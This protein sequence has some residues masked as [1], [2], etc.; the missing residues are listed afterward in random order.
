MAK[1]LH[2][3]SSVRNAGSVSRQLTAEFLSK[4]QAVRSADVIVER[5]LA[6]NPVPHLSE[7]MMGAFFT[8]AEQRSLE[9]AQTVQLSDAL[10]AE[11]FDADVIVL[12]APMYNFSIS[13][14]LKAWIDHVTRAG[15]TF[16]YTEAGPVGMLE[17]KKVYVFTARGGY[18][19]HGPAQSLDFQEAYLRAVLGFIG[20]TDVTFIH[21]EGLAMGDSAVETALGRSRLMIGELVAT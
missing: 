13:S 9:Q 6:A 10:V 20:L 3:N 11:L 14:T 18:Y 17:G 5:D 7:R 4:W 19:T 15:V 2:I 1:I 12:G 16:K 8:P 21:A